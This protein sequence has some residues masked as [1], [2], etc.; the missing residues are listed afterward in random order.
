[1][2][3]IFL[4]VFN[5]IFIVLKWPLYIILSCFAL[6]IFLCSFWFI[7]YTFKGKRLKKG[8]RQTVKKESFFINYFISYQDK[9]F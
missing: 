3:D 1:M 4:S 7:F 5:G 8:S 9:L 2:F 6:F